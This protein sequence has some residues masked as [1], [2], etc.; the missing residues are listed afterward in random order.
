MLKIANNNVQSIT[1]I[2]YHSTLFKT[3]ED[4]ISAALFN[5][6]SD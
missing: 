4:C 3:K 1:Q 6:N 2:S 5:D